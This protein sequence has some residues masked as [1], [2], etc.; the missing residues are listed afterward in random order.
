[1][2]GETAAAS[3]KQT[4]SMHKNAEHEAEQDKNEPHTSGTLAR[5]RRVRVTKRTRC[6][7]HLMMFVFCFVPI[8]LIDRN[9]NG[10]VSIL[11]SS[12]S[13]QMV[14]TRCNRPRLVGLFEASGL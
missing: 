7:L 5:Q 14:Q 10:N 9:E 8:L 3:I 6:N 12:R 1:M 13:I 4:V 11:S 2:N